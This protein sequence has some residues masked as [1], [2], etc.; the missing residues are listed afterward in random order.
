MITLI[1]DI[2]VK[3]AI[4]MVWILI[5][6]TNFMKKHWIKQKNIVF[7]VLVLVVHYWHTDHI[8]EKSQI[9]MY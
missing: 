7:C 2:C 5:I 4:F 9:W 8:T 6:K 3:N 1:T